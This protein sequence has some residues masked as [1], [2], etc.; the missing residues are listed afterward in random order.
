MGAEVALFEVVEDEL[1][2][3]VAVEVDFFDDDVFLLLNLAGREGG[4]EE[5]VGKEL[6]AAV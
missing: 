1:G 4:M 2:G 6:E 5:N 3:T